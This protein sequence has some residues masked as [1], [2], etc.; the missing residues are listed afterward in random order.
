MPVYI[1]TGGSADVAGVYL[2]I[3]VG[4]RDEAPGMEGA[5]HFV[6]HLVFKGTASHGVGDVARAVEGAGGELNAWTSFDET[7]F[8]ASGPASSAPGFIEVLAEMARTARM[9]PMELERERLVVIEEI[10]SR[11]D[12]PEMLAGEALYGI[13]FGEH[14]YG[15]PI[16]G[17]ERTVKSMARADLRAFYETMYVPSNA[18]LAVVGPVD[19]DRVIAAAT[20]ALSSGGP[21]PTRRARPCIE[22]RPDARRINLRKPFSATRVEVG[23]RTPGHE[24]PRT[25]ALDAVA[26]LLGGGSSAPLDARLRRELGLCLGASAS[27]EPEA[28]AGMFVVSMDVQP[29]RVSESLEALRD[30]IGDVQRG[31]DRAELARVKAQILADRVYGR[32]GVDGRAHQ[33]VFH[34]RRFG[35]LDAM[36]RYDAAVAGLDPEIVRGEAGRLDLDQACVVVM[37]PRTARSRTAARHAPA[38]DSAARQRSAGDSPASVRAPARPGPRDFTLDNGLRVVLWPDSSELVGVRVVGIGGQL[39]AR[40]GS[41]GRVAA[42]SRMVTRGT[43]SCPGTDFAGRVESLAGGIGA[44]VGRSSQGLRADFLSEHAREA[45][46]L[47]CDVLLRPA[48]DAAELESVRGEMLEEL[49]QSD[50]EAADRV[51]ETLWATCFA[52]HPWS[53]RASGAPGTIRG[54]QVGQ[55]RADHLRWGCGRNLVVAMTGAF[56][57]DMAERVLRHQLS[58]LRPGAPILPQQ[59]APWAPPGTRQRVRR[60]AGWEQTHIAAVWPGLGAR[61]PDAPALELMSVALGSQGGRLFDEVREKRGLAYGVGCSV[62]DGVVP[63][64]FAASL[65]TDPA[66]ADEAERALFDCVMGARETLTDAEIESA[67]VQV[68]GA[69]DS[70][71]QFAG[72]RASALAFQFAYD[73]AVSQEDRQVAALDPF[74]WA[75]RRFELVTKEDVR[76]VARAVLSGPA[77][78]VRV[79]PKQDRG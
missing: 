71:R 4:S 63:G 21:R 59:T 46:L 11:D 43:E 56:D 31:V 19:V 37:E 58:R 77:L 66:K 33:I 44:F 12:D 60:R 61:H 76:R 79:D 24:S 26:M 40:K 29:G 42:W 17:F 8:H 70:D 52:G 39:V 36:R 10:R 1:E 53:V 20:R 7:V 67:R 47:T 73:I 5:A 28:D 32:E 78:V 45:L 18:C 54:I 72:S 16:I 35:D 50:D 75:R 13:A 38:P 51:A 55:L 25:P 9:D 41:A 14:P 27:L 74:G 49:A 2:W 64:V 22:L 3:D 48:F 23:W 15:R 57:P 30:V 69:I 6:E 34:D 65:A 62:Q 68:L